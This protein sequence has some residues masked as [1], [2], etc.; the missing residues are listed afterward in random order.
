[1]PSLPLMIGTVVAV[2]LILGVS[3]ACRSRGCA[4]DTAVEVTARDI[5]RGAHSG[6]QEQRLTVARDA[7]EWAALWAQ[8]GRL[9]L[10]EPGAPEIDFRE[11]MVIALF[12]GTRPN[13]GYS[14]AI[15]A[16]ERNP[17][18]LVVRATEQAPGPDRIVATVMTAPFHMVVVPRCVGEPTLELTA[19]TD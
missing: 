15:T 2:G 18:G 19:Q 9:E 17:E 11:E 1:M 16:I 7:E 14:V 5:G 10:P 8:H 3:V 6:V 4:S 13:S 12:L